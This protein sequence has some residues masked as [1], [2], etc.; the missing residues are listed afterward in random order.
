MAPSAVAPPPENTSELVKS[1]INH[2]IHDTAPSMSLDATRKSS[3]LAELDASKLVFTPNYNRRP[4]PEPNSPEVWTQSV[5]DCSTY[6]F[7]LLIAF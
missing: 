2:T 3:E 5:Y 1:G 7:G 6:P 4:V